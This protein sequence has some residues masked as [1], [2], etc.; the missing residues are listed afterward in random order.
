MNATAN[1]PKQDS[2]DTSAQ[3]SI[4]DVSDDQSS[5][6]KN[7][8]VI[9]PVKS[10]FSI[11]LRDVWT[12][13]ELLYFLTWRDVKIR[14]KQT[15]VGVLW[16]ILQPLIS[17][18]IF[19]VL[20]G[21]FVRIDTGNIPYSLFS[22]CGLVIWTY[23]QTTIN[24]SSNSLI[25]NTNLI[26]KIYFPRLII[27]VS[28]AG[29]GLV[30]LF[31]N[32]IVLAIIMI[33]YRADVHFQILLAPLFLFQA[34]LIS[35]AVGTLL[36]ALNARFRDV[37]QILPFMLQL[38]MFAS[39]VLYP[40]TLFPE[41]WRWTLALNPLTGVIEGFRASL[42]GN[43]FD[44]FAIGCSLVITVFLLFISIIVF[45]RMESDFADYI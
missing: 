26:T 33:F 16:V 21:R 36:S 8:V 17:M 45:Q 42:F 27:P 44:F 40:L 5:N 18:I 12:Y 35:V 2:N 9:K 10:I 7:I 38:W 11:G 25:G 43:E 37:K 6:S 41:K 24:N 28:A 39:P 19:S 23:I 30:D 14:Y 15:V 1:F 34:V 3:N 22:F 31:I 20:F 4:E 29:A 13:R 32:M